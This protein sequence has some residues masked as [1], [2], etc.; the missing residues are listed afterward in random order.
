MSWYQRVSFFA[1]CLK[2]VVTQRFGHDWNMTSL[3]A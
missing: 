2:K 3:D 1:H